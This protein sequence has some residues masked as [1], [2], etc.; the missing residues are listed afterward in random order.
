MSKTVIFTVTQGRTGTKSL[1]DFLKIHLS[2]D[3]GLKAD[4]YHERLDQW[5]LHRPTHEINTVY[6]RHGSVQDVKMWWT[7]KFH[8]ILKEME[9]N[10]SKIYVET[11]HSLCCAGLLDHLDILLDCGCSVILIGLSRSPVSWARSMHRRM[12]M[13]DA[14]NAGVWWIEP[15]TCMIA[16]EK[17]KG[18]LYEGY[19]YAGKLR[20]YYEEIEMRKVKACALSV[21]NSREAEL[22]YLEWN[23]GVE[24]DHMHY[25]HLLDMLD[26]ESKAFL[27]GPGKRRMP[28]SNKFPNGVNLDQYIRFEDYNAALEKEL[29]S[30]NNG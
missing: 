14:T 21:A 20:W 1:A 30:R 28:Q 23:I 17:F 9:T 13:F 16:E 10:V 26:F 22:G 3:T 29:W 5:G 24:R 4:I 2:A 8:A 11:D 6:N 25:L 7:R 12:D 19:G 15:S 27:S 18:S